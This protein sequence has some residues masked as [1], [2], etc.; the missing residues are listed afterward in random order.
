MPACHRRWPP[1]G[2]RPRGPVA[3]P[4]EPTGAGSGPKSGPRRRGRCGRRPCSRH[5]RRGRTGSTPPGDQLESRAGR[6]GPAGFGARHPRRPPCNGPRPAGLI[7]R[8]PSWPWV[9]GAGDE[10]AAP[11]KPGSGPARMLE[12]AVGPGPG[13][14]GQPVGRTGSAA[15]PHPGGSALPRELPPALHG[16]GLAAAGTKGPAARRRGV[17][18]ALHEGSRSLQHA[19]IQHCRSAGAA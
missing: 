2:G 7:R 9:P 18:G 12:L 5:Q 15:S 4:P 17:A 19:S 14:L 3:P 6:A 10:S 11:R 8:P 16:N 13:R 1:D